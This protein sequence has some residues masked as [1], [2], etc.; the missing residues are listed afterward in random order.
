MSESSVVQSLVR[1][2][3]WNWVWPDERNCFPIPVRVRGPMPEGQP[4]P[5]KRTLAKRAA[6]RNRGRAA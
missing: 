3:A 4:G 1:V 6:R 2:S 5:S